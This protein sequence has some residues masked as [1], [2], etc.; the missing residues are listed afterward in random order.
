M[1]GDPDA[2][3]RFVLPPLRWPDAAPLADR[4]VEIM[5]ALTPTAPASA[6]PWLVWIWA[7]GAL[8]FGGWH[9]VAYHR[10]LQRALI[11]ATVRDGGVDL[12]TT[13]AVEGPA[14]V[15]LLHRRILLPL[16]F[17]GR[18]TPAE[19]ALALAHERAHHARRS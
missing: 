16:D 13:G 8:L 2:A 9:L 5:W 17:A 18:F 1:A 11:G 4:P 6:T 19:R 3:L 14:A 12:V 15:G 7:A 10:F